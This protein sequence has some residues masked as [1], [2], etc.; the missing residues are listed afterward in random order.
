MD[1]KYLDNVV[2]AK[3]SLQIW[4]SYIEQLH[5]GI[6][7]FS[8][9]NDLN[10]NN[11]EFG[12]WYYG[13]GQTFVS[14]DTFKA[15]GPFYEEMYDL[16]LDYLTLHNKPLKKGFFSNDKEKKN[17]KL[18]KIYQDLK[19]SARKLIKSVEIFEE[20]LRNSPLYDDSY[21]KPSESTNVEVFVS[22][23]IANLED[24]ILESASEEKSIKKSDNTPPV[25]FEENDDKVDFE[26]RLKEEVAKIKKQLESEFV[27]K[28]ED[29]KEAVNLKLDNSTAEAENISKS[30]TPPEN[31]LK[32]NKLLDIDIDEEI[33]RILS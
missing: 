9:E 29:V 1:H 20:K 22:T 3:E 12:K 23:N 2:N 7:M 4:F 26:K 14:F 10:R 25:E 5:N 32:D 16:Y 28:Q 17:K 18:S 31:K 33:R 8:S 24:E 15:L 11:T 21:S 6:N 30:K 13:E 19:Q 27:S